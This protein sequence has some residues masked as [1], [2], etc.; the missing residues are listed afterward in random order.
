M[1]APE[2]HANTLTPS[3]GTD[4]LDSWKEIA[5]YLGRHIRTVQ[6]WEA[7]E[8][9]P[10][11][12]HKH[13]DRDSVYAFK[14]ELDTWLLASAARGAYGAVLN[15]DEGEQGPGSGSPGDTHKGEALVE[16]SKLPLAPRGAGK[17]S[18]STP[19][20]KAALG[21]ATVAGIVL[22]AAYLAPAPPAPRALSYRQITS[23]GR[24]K[25]GTLATDGARI[26]FTERLATGMAVAQV[27]VSGGMVQTLST[28]FQNPSVVD[29]NVNRAE[30]LVVDPARIAGQPHA[31]WSL[32]LSGGQPRRMGHALADSA[33]WSPDGNRLAY[34][35]GEDLFVANRE[36]DDARKIAVLPGVVES[37]YWS[38]DSRHLHATV[39]RPDS[40][41]HRIWELSPAGADH[42]EV[43]RE[44]SPGDSMMGGAWSPD[45]QHFF[46]TRTLRASEIWAAGERARAVWGSARAV[47]TRLTSG[48]AQITAMVSS[49]TGKR[50][51]LIGTETHRELLRLDS[52]SGNFV[53]YLA[54]VSAQYANV[55]PD[56][57]WIAYSDITDSPTLWRRRP[58]GSGAVQ[59]TFPSM[60]EQLMRWSPDGKRI[61]FMG[62]QDPHGH[63]QV[64]VVPAEGG[65]CQPVL[66]SSYLQ[67]APSWSP[68]GT[69]VAFGELQ[70]DPARPAAEMRIHVVNLQT[71]QDTT[72]PGSA[73]LWTA[74][75]SPD[76]RHMAAIT[77]DSRTLKVFDFP[78]QQWEEVSTAADI[79]DLDWS[80]DNDH[81]YFIDRLPPR[82]P[83][84]F[85]VG[86][87]DHRREQIAS[88]K[89]EP[90]ISS[91]WLGVTPDDTL[92]VANNAD[93]TEI[94]SLDWEAP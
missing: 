52:H 83:A 82:G 44:W 84:I 43:Y 78:T 28:A 48:P 51:F 17:R 92:L 45:G 34:G 8:G 1:R 31:L 74:R 57:R 9:L 49:P 79:S 10:I 63:W 81:I 3:T 4:R 87:R 30:L 39:G 70:S 73:G 85:R 7:R 21:V 76:G 20:W 56:G 91:D 23:D 12:R 19:R 26:Y 53:P 40:P 11:H 68:D 58:D 77:A 14:H 54:G 88:L 13:T 65:D 46:F 18:L 61:A 71:H 55:S 41:Y 47:P 29:V 69:R 5:D 24:A 64:Y 33:A 35:E 16:E 38:T 15:A 67:G 2:S 42:H 50:L 25:E 93:R 37:I 32:P 62:M 90:P 6:R 94:Y 66:P 80:H 89:R 59:L 72:L 86:W 27:P 75:W 36:G 60:S 22:L